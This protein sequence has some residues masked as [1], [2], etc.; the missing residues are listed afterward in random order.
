[1]KTFILLVILS[2]G[3][4]GG[5]VSTETISQDFSSQD[6]CRKALFIIRQKVAQHGYTE[7]ITG[8]CFEK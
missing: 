2:T 8:G 1:M 7:V 5:V 6:S 4:P 3:R